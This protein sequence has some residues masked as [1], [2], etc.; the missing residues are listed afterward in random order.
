MYSDGTQ[1][2]HP[3][4][5]YLHLLLGPRY[6]PCGWLQ[7]HV[8][9][10]FHGAAKTDCFRPQ[11]NLI[12]RPRQFMRASSTS[13]CHRGIPVIRCPRYSILYTLPI[14]QRLWLLRSGGY[15][16]DAPIHD[17]ACVCPI[18]LSGLRHTNRLPGQTSTRQSNGNNTRRVRVPLVQPAPRRCCSFLALRTSAAVHGSYH[19]RRRPLAWQR[20]CCWCEVC[21]NRSPRVPRRVV[22]AMLCL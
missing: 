12:P 7:I 19:A 16:R 21:V 11:P 13:I 4:Y 2:Y 15:A 3:A 14:V 18:R 9:T 10:E 6:T 20:R 22:A 5:E 17:H 1:T 8:V